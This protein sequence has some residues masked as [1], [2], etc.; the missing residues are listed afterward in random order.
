MLD[1][2][3][4]LYGS[5]GRGDLIIFL[6]FVRELLDDLGGRANEDRFHRVEPVRGQ[7]AE[8]VPTGAR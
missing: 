2:R 1:V 8:Q 7:V 3:I 6:P 5:F 4:G